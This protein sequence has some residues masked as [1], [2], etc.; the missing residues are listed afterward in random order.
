M[1]EQEKRKHR[2]AFAGH[3]P[4]KLN[5]DKKTVCQLLEKEIIKAY[6]DGFNVF[7]SGGARGVDMWAAEIVLS[8]KESCEDMKLI[9]AIPFPNYDSRW[10]YE[11][12][13]ELQA[14]LNAADLVVTVCKGY[15]DGC[16]Q[17]RNE[18]VI[19]HSSRLIAVWDGKPS[20]TG[21][22]VRY[23]QEQG[24]EIINLI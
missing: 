22:A 21:N 7:V 12:R 16:Y 23:A 2:C 11:D 15:Y 3:R 19:S 17:V 24:K 18:W 6:N 8:L 14:I 5:I 10:Y 1:D 13:A 9:C 20:G 4:E